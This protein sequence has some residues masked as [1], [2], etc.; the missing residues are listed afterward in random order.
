MEGSGLNSIGDSVYVYVGNY[1]EE[2]RIRIKKLKEGAEGRMEQDGNKWISLTMEQWES[3]CLVK[4][5]VSK[6][7]EL[8]T[9][10]DAV[11]KRA[12]RLSPNRFVSVDR[13]RSTF[14]NAFVTLI[15]IRIYFMGGTDL[16]DNPTRYGITL[17]PEQ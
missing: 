3:L 14:I 17:K 12:W 4:E 5:E 9:G 6:Q 15:N 13:I 8:V 10:R 7:I 2:V 11:T 16:P 1:Q